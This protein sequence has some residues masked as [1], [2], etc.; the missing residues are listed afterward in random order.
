MEKIY[1]ADDDADIL[2]L[3]EIFLKNEGYD[4]KTFTNGDALYAYF[5]EQNA[6]LVILD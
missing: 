6:D 1:L 4:V 3:L 2:R 5:I